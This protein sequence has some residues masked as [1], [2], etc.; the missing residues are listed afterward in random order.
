MTVTANPLPSK[1]GEFDIPRRAIVDALHDAER[2]IRNAMIEVEKLGADPLL[3]DA[4]TKLIA[5]KDLVSDWLEGKSGLTA[6][7]AQTPAATW[8]VNGEPDPHDNRYDC[9]RAAL[10]MGGL[11]DDELANAA[12]LNYDRRPDFQAMIEGRAFSPIVYMTAVKDR[13]RWLSRA[14]EKAKAAK[15]AAPTYVEL[16]RQIDEF[17]EL[18]MNN[19]SEDQVRELNY[20][21]VRVALAAQEMA[22][23][24]APARYRLVPIE[25]TPEMQQA[26]AQA[27]RFDTTILNKLWTGNAVFRA[28][29]AAAPQGAAGHD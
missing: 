20:W 13:I 23:P 8:R 14:L 21:G 4:G 28:M 10:T 1:Y 15:L 6:P 25:P 24:V 9:E 19:Y 11:T 5:A 3:T 18:N 27:I 16:L 2:A 17:P 26:G 12:F 7:V 22:G 29:L